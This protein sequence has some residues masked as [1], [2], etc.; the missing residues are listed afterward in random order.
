MKIRKVERLPANKCDICNAV[1]TDHIIDAP[2]HSGPWANMCEKCSYSH[3]RE[4]ATK[5]ILTVR[6]EKK[7]TRKEVLEHANSIDEEELQSMM[8]DGDVITIDGCVTEP[9]GHCEHGYP[10]PLLVLGII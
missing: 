8:F 4:P 2:T 9:D 1:C 10:S 3:G 7:Y 6:E 5:F